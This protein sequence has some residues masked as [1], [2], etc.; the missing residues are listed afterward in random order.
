MVVWC[1]TYL[2]PCKSSEELNLEAETTVE[3]YQVVIDCW[4]L[5]ESDES[6]SNAIQIKLMS[7]H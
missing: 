6:E 2:F 3:K 4:Q 1:G 5:E 7:I